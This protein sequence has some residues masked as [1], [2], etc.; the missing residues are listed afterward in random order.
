MRLK[1]F[2]S[3]KLLSVE[4]MLIQGSQASG[5]TSFDKIRYKKRE[6]TK[7]CI[8]LD[9]GL[10]IISDGILTFPLL[11]PPNPEFLHA[12]PAV[13]QPFGRRSHLMVR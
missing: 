3:E 12:I 9:Q 2:K 1:A 7:R 4:K 6:K 11:M 13:R 5:L 8:T 10:K